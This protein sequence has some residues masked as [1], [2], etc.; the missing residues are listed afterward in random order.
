MS[1]VKRLPAK[2]LDAYLRQRY[3]CLSAALAQA[4]VDQKYLNAETISTKIIGRI[5]RRWAMT[6]EQLVAAVEEAAARSK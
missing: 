4:G 1:T 3:S 6:P 2:A 5:A